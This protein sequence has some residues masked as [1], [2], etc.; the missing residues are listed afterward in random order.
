MSK[1]E[2]SDVPAAAPEAVVDAA[3]IVSLAGKVVLVTGA[4]SGIGRAIAVACAEAGADVAISYN[5]NERG[6]ADVANAI[7]AA[8]RRSHITRVNATD[9]DD[10]QR[11]ARDVPAGFGSVDRWP[12]NAGP[13]S[14][15]GRTKTTPR[16]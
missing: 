12:N 2:L 10:V 8:G 3:S 5:T 13:N 16:L 7:Q 6:A 9:P 11:H 4:S 15:T 14:L 1:R